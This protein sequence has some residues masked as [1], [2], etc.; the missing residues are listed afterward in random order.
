M[1]SLDKRNSQDNPYRYINSFA[2]FGSK[3]GYKPGL[4]RIEQLLAYFGHPESKLKIIH[5]AGSNGKG[6]TIA[7]LESIYYSAGYRVGAY[8]SPHL[9]EFNERIRV[10]K[11]L[12]TTTE[13]AEIVAEIKAA[14]K[15]L[16]TTPYGRPSY[17]EI[18]TVIAFLYFYRKGV[19]L[20]MLEVGLGGRLDATNVIKK[21]LLS[22]ITSISLE[23]TAIL[24]DSIIEI[25]R[26]KAG[27]IKSNCPVLT[28]VNNK[29]A[30]EVIRELSVNNKATLKSI[31]N[32]FTFILKES[33]LEGQ[34]FTLKYRGLGL[35]AAGL[36]EGKN[37]EKFKELEGDYF[38]KLAGKHQLRNAVLAVAVVAENTPEFK[39]DKQDLIAGLKTAF[40][41]GRIELF[42]KKPQVLLDG[43][44]NPESLSSLIE[45]LLSNTG[46]L[47]KKIVVLS[48][49]K[50]KDIFAMIRLF[51]LL[52]SVELIITDNGNERA[53]PPEKIKSIADELG[54]PNLLYPDIRTAIKQALLKI[55]EGDFLCITGSLYTVGA[56]KK[57]LLS[58]N[59]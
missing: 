54:I 39:V 57:Y 18:V 24:G 3:D 36:E 58:N 34:V 33:G 7:F 4:E 45:F 26:E 27:I 13:L 52:D 35:K 20:V 5:V 32:L 49:L 17:F 41:P 53:L 43:A 44:H 6:S 38:I 56:A 46:E 55:S 29:D 37:R 31:D 40:I 50:D 9:L 2:K 14:V 11:E 16:S 51:K 30:L 42:S 59:S 25:A 12:I 23:H 21:P 1:Y 15:W 22:V 19:D 47:G 8:T 10:N 48:I 28:A